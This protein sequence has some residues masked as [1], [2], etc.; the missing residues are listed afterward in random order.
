MSLLLRTSLLLA[1][2]ALPFAVP[3]AKNDQSAAADPGHAMT[4]SQEGSDVV[5]FCTELEDVR[6]VGSNNRIE[7]N[8]PCRSVNIVGSSNTAILRI[9][10]D[11]IS[12]NGNDNR[13]HWAAADRA[14]PA[15]TVNGRGNVVEQQKDE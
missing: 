3:A 8:G 6:F 7:A 11:Q 12:V 15:T 14:K 13:I 9:P 1:L 4:V 5:H 10:P 2:G